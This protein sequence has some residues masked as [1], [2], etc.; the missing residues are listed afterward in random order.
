L[1][2]IWYAVAQLVEALCYKPEVRGFD[3]VFRLL[4]P[5]G[6]SMALGSIRPLTE[7]ITRGISWG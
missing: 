6:R 1:F 5:T 2:G 3:L 7:T 4:N